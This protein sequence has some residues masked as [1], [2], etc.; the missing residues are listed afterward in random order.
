MR[1][2]SEK[3]KIA[4]LE[5]ENIRIDTELPKYKKL[6]EGK[7]KEN[8]TKDNVTSS[9]RQFIGN[10]NSER[11][12]LT[13]SDN[14]LKKIGENNDNPVRD[15]M[16]DFF[17]ESEND[18][19][20]LSLFKQRKL[21]Y[22]LWRVIK[23]IFEP[24]KKK[25]YTL[26]LDQLFDRIKVE[27]G[28]EKEFIDRIDQYISLIKKAQVLHQEAQEEELFDKLIIHVYESVLSI[29]G[30]NKYIAEDD[31][32]KLQ[33]KCDKKLSIDYI[34]NFVRVIPDDVVEKKLKADNLQIFDNY[35]VL[36][37]DPTNNSTNNTKKEKEIIEENKKK[38]P[39]LFGIIAGSDKL[40]YIADWVDEFCDLTLD[41]VVNKIG[42]VKTLK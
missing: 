19:D 36:Y 7:N 18:I 11:F 40:Y 10:E 12:N 28:K 16:L 8:I 33:R 2:I 13:I 22:R 5:G 35:A 29:S 38:D 17:L 42:E 31:L 1:L 41:Q 15:N 23:K 3:N 20:T 39:I 25:T 30:F 9:I 14:I 37:Y 21:R 6:K 27:T 34:K 32:I 26:K 24:K 4:I